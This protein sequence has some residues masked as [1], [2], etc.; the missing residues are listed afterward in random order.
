MELHRR[1]KL[2]SP[3]RANARTAALLLAVATAVGIAALATPAAASATDEQPPVPSAADVSVLRGVLALQ[4]PALRQSV[5]STSSAASAAGKGGP[6]Q[7][8]PARPAI[9]GQQEH[10]QHGATPAI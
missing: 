5:A 10:D 1:R 8:Q 9:E 7:N 6:A 2:A 3:A 4:Y